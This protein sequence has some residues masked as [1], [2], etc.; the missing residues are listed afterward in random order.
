LDPAIDD[1]DCGGSLTDENATTTDGSGWRLLFSI[2]NGVASLTSPTG[3]VI[4]PVPQNTT[5]G[6]AKATDSNGN[7]ITV[8]GSGVFTDTLGT[9]SNRLGDGHSC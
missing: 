9:G 8:S 7:Q 1:V 5:T 4:N 3:Q 6:T 2:T